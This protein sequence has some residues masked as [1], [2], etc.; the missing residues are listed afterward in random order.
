MFLARI[1]EKTGPRVYIEDSAKQ[2]AINMDAGLDID[3][4]EIE[5]LP[6]AT[7]LHP[8]NLKAGPRATGQA[9]EIAE[10]ESNG[11]TVGSAEVAA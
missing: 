11:Q 8:V 6:N 7:V 3:Y 9:M 2:V 4:F 1:N 10:I 5:L